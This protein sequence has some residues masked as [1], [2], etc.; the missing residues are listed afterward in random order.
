LNTSCFIA[1]VCLYLLTHKCR[2]TLQVDENEPPWL[3]WLPGV[4]YWISHHVNPEVMILSTVQVLVFFLCHSWAGSM[5]DKNFWNLIFQDGDTASIMT[6]LLY[7][8]A[9]CFLG[10]I[11]PRV[12]PDFAAVMSLPPFFSR[13]NEKIVYLVAVQVVDAKMVAAR[14]QMSE[15]T[16]EKDCGG[17]DS[18]IED[19]YIKKQSTIPLAVAGQW[20]NSSEKIGEEEAATPA[21]RQSKR[22]EP[23][24]KE[25]DTPLLSSNANDE[26]G[27]D[28]VGGS[29]NSLEVSPASM[30]SRAAKK[31]GNSKAGTMRKKAP[32]ASMVGKSGN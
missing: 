2:K 30:K 21:G 32:D 6:A 8:L 23:K 18:R 25:I 12:I 4:F 9:L 1:I 11:L 16:K 14:A 3:A 22:K 5:I 7:I 31:V 15:E 10:F 20:L 28:S 19:D 26:G 17:R 13:S 27:G 24:D 29:A